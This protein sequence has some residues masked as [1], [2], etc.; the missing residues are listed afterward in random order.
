MLYYFLTKNQE[1]IL[2]MTE[3]KT[4]ALAGIRPSSAQLKKGLPIFFE[5]LK[6]VLLLEGSDNFRTSDTNAMVQAAIASDEPALAIADGHPSEALVAESA[7]KHGIELLR[8]G[9]TLSH[10]VHAYGDMC[11]AITELATEMKESITPAEFHDLNRCLDTAIAGAVTAFEEQNS[12]KT[13]DNQ[14]EHLGFLAHELRNALTSVNFSIQLIKLGTVGF[15]GNTGK[16]LD[17]G[18][19]RIEY[20]IDK[21][22]T[23][24]RLKSDSNPIKESAILIQLVDQ[25][26]F[27]ANIE[28]NTRKQNIVI[29]IDPTLMIVAD[30]QL[31]Y[32][33]LSNLLQNAIKYTRIGGL[34]QLRGYQSK[35]QIIIEVEDECGGLKNT[36]V[37]L[38]KPYVQENNN[39]RGI[40]LGLTIAQKAMTLNQGSIDVKNLP[41]KGCVFT[42]TLPLLAA[43]NE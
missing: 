39:R 12:I 34:I 18:L 21:S 14:V 20:L 9:Y 13:S 43:K 24:V 15:G 3:Q 10:V 41:G 23:E 2:N 31:F 38:F 1:K 17:R 33:A 35:D 25:I 27:T 32:S 8:L 16:V 7:G 28:A 40:G 29:D 36:E 42:I 11:Q 26:V 6:E 5:Q 4:M 30:Q 22:L 37:D 19:K